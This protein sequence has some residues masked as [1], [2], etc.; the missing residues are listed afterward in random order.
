MS[1]VC[2][3]ELRF[4]I[5]G[6]ILKQIPA[7]TLSLYRAIMVQYMG[8]FHPDYQVVLKRLFLRTGAFLLSVQKVDEA[9]GKNTSI[10]QNAVLRKYLLIS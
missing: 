2:P 8:W 5:N 10:L 7:T 1:D 4:F 3:K 6:L 9:G